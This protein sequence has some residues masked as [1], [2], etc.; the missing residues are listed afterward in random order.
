MVLSPVCS[1]DENADPS[2]TRVCQECVN[3]S[4]GKIHCKPIIMNSNN[5]NNSTSIIYCKLYGFDVV[6]GLS[7]A[8]I[9]GR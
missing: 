4:T 5:N 8:T 7:L 9:K 3:N 2:T 6:Y 1:T